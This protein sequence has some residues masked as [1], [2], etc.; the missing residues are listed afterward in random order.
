[1]GAASAE[2]AW[3]YRSNEHASGGL[4]NVVYRSRAVAPMSPPELDALTRVSQAR[5]AREDLTGVMFYDNERFFQWLEGPEASVNRVMGSICK[6]PRHSDIEVLDERSAQA[7][8]FGAWNM[9]LEAPDPNVT[10]WLRDVIV[11]PRDIVEAL[12]ARPE[13]AP[14]LLVRLVPG[15][16]N[17]A[18]GKIIRLDAAHTVPLA[19]KTASILK[20][21][22]LSSVI[23]TLLSDAAAAETRVVV[24][25]A[26]A[27]VNDLAELLIE[28]DETAALEL[29]RELRGAVRSTPNLFAQVLEPAARRLGDLWSSDDCTEL[30]LTLGLCRLQRAVRIMTE[31]TSLALPYGAPQPAVLIVPEPG[32]LHLLGAA[33]DGTTLGNAG[34]SPHCEYPAND[35]AL[36]ELL[37]AEWF[38]V[39]DLSLSI[40]LRREHFL[41][42][43]TETIAQARRASRNPNL[44]VVVGGRVFTETSGAGAGVGADLASKT[45]GNVDRS[46]LRLM[47]ATKTST[48]TLL[49]AGEVESTP[50]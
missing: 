44:I 4:A 14:D 35:K 6:D 47:S 31:D 17:A 5:N 19:R 2:A 9:K 30:D 42:R 23:P 20:T 49:E 26:H 15:S 32:E 43:I 37:S 45:S 22:L 29:A 41:P 33:L 10:S 48:E 40:A 27:R 39:L 16:G 18:S 46:I 12:R 11:P 8:A 36:Q 24:P 1:M 21:V 13:A 28:G 34:W 50:S 7:R 38:D 3:P 25:P